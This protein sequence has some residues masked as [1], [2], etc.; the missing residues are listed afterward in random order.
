MT[1]PPTFPPILGKLQPP[2]SSSS[3]CHSSKNITFQA[4]VYVKAATEGWLLKKIDFSIFYALCTNFFLFLCPHFLH[5]YSRALHNEVGDSRGWRISWA[6]TLTGIGDTNTLTMAEEKLV[7]LLIMIS[8]RGKWGSE[9]H[10]AWLWAIVVPRSCNHNA[11]RW[12]TNHNFRDWKRMW[13]CGVLK[14]EL[15][16]CVSHLWWP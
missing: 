11:H 6:L 4:F 7:T 1:L 15:L 2:H 3:R 13:L 9:C 12:F 10:C 8:T 16:Y 14:G 5:I